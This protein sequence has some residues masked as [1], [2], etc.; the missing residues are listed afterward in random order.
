MKYTGAWGTRPRDPGSAGSPL[1]PQHLPLTLPPL[2]TQRF[3]PSSPLQGWPLPKSPMSWYTELPSPSK[4]T[5]RHK[6]RCWGDLLLKPIRDLPHGWHLRANSL[7]RGTR[8]HRPFQ[9]LHSWKLFFP[10]STQRNIQSEVFNKLDYREKILEPYITWNTPTVIC[11]ETMI[12]KQPSNLPLHFPW[13][14][15]HNHCYFKRPSKI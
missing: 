8:K 9:D 6:G 12:C 7:V 14:N 1:T 10:V 15:P 13:Q 5:N 11:Q 3:Q 4:E 2:F